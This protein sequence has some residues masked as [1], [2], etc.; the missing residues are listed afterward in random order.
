MKIFSRMRKPRCLT[1][2]WHIEYWKVRLNFNFINQIGFSYDWIH[3][4]TH[5]KS[6]NINSMQI[7]CFFLYTNNNV[8]TCQ[9][10]NVLI[11]IL[12]FWKFPFYSFKFGYQNGTR[13]GK[14]SYMTKNGV[15][16]YSKW[17]DMEFKP[18]YQRTP[19]S[20]F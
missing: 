10:D 3:V 15:P 14:W 18:P 2:Q 19:F 12:Q 6:S 16:R 8:W 9:N 5:R 4:E 1:L 11:F 13:P 7:Y 17:I 20:E